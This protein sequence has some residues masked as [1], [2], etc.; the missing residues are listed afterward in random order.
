MNDRKI[1]LGTAITILQKEDFDGSLTVNY[2]GYEQ[3]NFSKIVGDC[4]LVN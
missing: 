4:I 3:T 2:Q 1:S